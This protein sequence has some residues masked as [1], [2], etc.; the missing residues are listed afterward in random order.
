MTDVTWICEECGSFQIVKDI[1]EEE[2]E[3]VLNLMRA[4][5]SDNKARCDDCLGID[6]NP[7][8]SEM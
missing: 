3:R 4:S 1:T 5:S 8:T 6:N 7:Y 2:H